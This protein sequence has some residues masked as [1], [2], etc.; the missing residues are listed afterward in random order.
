[1]KLIVGLG[2][3]GFIYRGSRHNIGFSAVKALA[4]FYKADFKKDRRANSL[5][6]KCRIKTQGVVLSLPLTFM[7]LSGIAVEALL[8]EY[9]VDLDNL[10]V[11][12]D[13]L[14]LEF[15][16]LRI[17]PGGSSGGH[18]GLQSII[19]SLGSGRFARLRVGIGRP[20]VNIDASRHVLSHFNRQEKAALQGIIARALDCCE[21]WATRGVAESMNTFNRR[22]Q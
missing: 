2:N 12:C 20:G 18:R 4:G 1:M 10:L 14:D 22:H 19:E 5:S 6:A 9:K 17:R 11:V 21:S 16:R 13:D 8:K 15:G 3:P 7:N